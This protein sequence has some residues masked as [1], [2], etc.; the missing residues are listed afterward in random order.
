LF[1]VNS[2]NNSS[3]AGFGKIVKFSKISFSK[4]STLLIS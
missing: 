1:K 3:D 2:K 4:I